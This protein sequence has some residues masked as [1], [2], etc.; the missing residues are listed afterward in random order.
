MGG[1]V[2]GPQ[3][4]YVKTR[5]VDWQLNKTHQVTKYTE[6]GVISNFGQVTDDVSQ[7]IHDNGLK[8][9]MQ[10]RAAHR[11]T[12]AWAGAAPNVANPQNLN[13]VVLNEDDIVTDMVEDVFGSEGQWIGYRIAANLIPLPA[14]GS[15]TH[16]YFKTTLK[17]F[18]RL[19]SFDCH[20]VPI[21]CVLGNFNDFKTHYVLG[22]GIF[23]IGKGGG[24]NPRSLE[25][26]SQT[27][28]T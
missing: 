25:F 22:V 24:V 12:V 18:R 20:V 2:P 9:G 16:L 10:F 17:N 19:H 21:V 27:I 15:K 28:T 3:G 23:T 13:Y 7:V 4:L 8:L 14:A 5:S 6:V 26:E 1:G 11:P